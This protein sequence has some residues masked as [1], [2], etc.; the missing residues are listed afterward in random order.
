MD[1]SIRRCPPVT[2]TTSKVSSPADQ[3]AQHRRFQPVNNETHETD[4]SIFVPDDPIGDCRRRIAGADTCPNSDTVRG[5]PVRG[6]APA[7]G[8]RTRR[9]LLRRR[10]APSRP[11]PP[12][13]WPSP[14]C[15]KKK[16]DASSSIRP[17]FDGTNNP[18]NSASANGQPIATSSLST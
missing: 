7:T 5:T 1:I 18:M 13:P 10:S 17:E 3:I 2:S 16:R 12:R 9:P 11:W 8:R 4:A 15:H 6:R 14:P